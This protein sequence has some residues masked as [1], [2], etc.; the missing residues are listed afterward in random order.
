LV[1]SLR[2]ELSRLTA[3]LEYHKTLV[4]DLR[5]A[6]SSPQSP[7]SKSVAIE[8]QALRQEVEKLGNRVGTLGGIIQEGLETRQRTRSDEDGV[9]RVRADVNRRQ[10]RMGAT[11]VDDFRHKALPSKLR[12]GLH[13]AAVTQ[14]VLMPPTIPRPTRRSQTPP[15][16]DNDDLSSSPTSNRHS[17]RDIHMA[18]PSSPFPSIRAE[19]EESFFSITLLEDPAKD[20]SQVEDVRP[21]PRRAAKS[22]SG[23]EHRNQKMPNT[24]ALSRVVAELEADFKHYKA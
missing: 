9:D 6:H 19:D 20:P 1:K 21:E 5:E 16:V 18:G 22:S 12:Q 24:A 17:R 2:V 15:Q 8:L 4:A 3:E 7:R 23:D 11:Q 10:A 13:Q 14:P